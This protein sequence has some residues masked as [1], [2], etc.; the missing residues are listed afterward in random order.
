MCDRMHAIALSVRP[1]PVAR[2]HYARPQ[3][4]RDARRPD[5]LHGIR[6]GTKRLTEELGHRE[7]LRFGHRLDVIDT[8]FAQAPPL[9]GLG[10]DE[11]LRHRHPVDLELVVPVQPDDRALES[12]PGPVCLATEPAG[13]GKAHPCPCLVVARTALI[14]DRDRIAID[15][16]AACK[17]AALVV[18]LLGPRGEPACRWITSYRPLLK[19]LC[20]PPVWLAAQQ[21]NR[22]SS[23]VAHAKLRH[24]SR[25]SRVCHWYTLLIGA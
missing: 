20:V 25:C 5:H 11:K 15:A 2:K 12:G 10:L 24:K 16:F 9:D 4:R 19:L 1:S 6:V 13:T 21:L 8:T 22:H 3:M 23:G 18:C 17:D 7:P 14:Q